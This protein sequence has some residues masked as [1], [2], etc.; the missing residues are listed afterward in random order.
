MVRELSVVTARVLRGEAPPALIMPW[1]AHAT[2]GGRVPTGAVPLD[3]IARFDSI[4]APA[5]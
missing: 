1:M 2:L 3:A 5:A 4:V